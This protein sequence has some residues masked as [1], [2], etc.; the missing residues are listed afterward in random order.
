MSKKECSLIQNLL[1][2]YINSSVSDDAKDVIKEHLEKC[3]DCN[4]LYMQMKSDNAQSKE[5]EVRSHK[6]YLKKFNKKLSLLKKIIIVLLI[7]ILI[8]FVPLVIKLIHNNYILDSAYNKLQSIQDRNEYYVKKE[9]ILLYNYTSDFSSS[10]SIT[11]YYYKDGKYKMVCYTK[12]DYENRYEVYGQEGC[13]EEIYVYYDSKKISYR[14]N[15]GLLVNQKGQ[16]LEGIYYNISQ[17][18]I[19][20]FKLLDIFGTYETKI[21]NGKECYVIRKNSRD[22]KSL[23]YNECWIDKDTMMSVRNV[24]NT[25][26][27]NTQQYSDSKLLYV[28]EKEISDTDVELPEL[29]GFTV[30]NK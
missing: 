8:I 24:M 29:E 23:N 11:E 16:V 9:T 26:N 1:N 13:N 15:Y 10:C 28:E 21:Y 5:Q 30:N 19:T 17:W 25:Q 12:N 27:E 7:I 2:D 4:S 3:K 20:Q 18:Y 14:K 22:S 6:E